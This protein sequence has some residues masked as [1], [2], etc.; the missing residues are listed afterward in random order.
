MR[1]DEM[2]DVVRVFVLMMYGGGGDGERSEVATTLAASDDDRYEMGGLWNRSAAMASSTNCLP[3][4]AD[5]ARMR[6][7]AFLGV[8][9]R[10]YFAGI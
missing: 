1:D 9:S 5:R 6:Y 4:G 3:Y 2:N 10:I 7:V 8:R